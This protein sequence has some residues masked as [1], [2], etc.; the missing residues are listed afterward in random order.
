MKCTT[1][2]KKLLKSAVNQR[3]RLM[4]MGKG[5]K[6]PSRLRTII[7][8]CEDKLNRFPSEESCKQFIKKHYADI[9]YLIPARSEED[10]RIQQLTELL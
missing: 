9:R 8:I 2:Y 10:K 5:K 4:R 7:M 3:K 6:D 1:P